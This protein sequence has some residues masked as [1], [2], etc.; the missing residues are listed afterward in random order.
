MP[1]KFLAYIN[2]G[3][4]YSAMGDEE[5]SSVNHKIALKCAIQMSS[6]AIGNL[7]KIGNSKFVSDHGKNEDVC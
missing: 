5:M 3:I 7:G 6:V 1:G 2:L 4:V